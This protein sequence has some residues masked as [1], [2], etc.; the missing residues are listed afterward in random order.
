MHKR[1]CTAKEGMGWVSDSNLRSQLIEMWGTLLPLS[2]PGTSASK[3]IGDK[4]LIPTD[5][6]TMYT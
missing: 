5:T 2:R 4:F 3:G 6:K 1:E